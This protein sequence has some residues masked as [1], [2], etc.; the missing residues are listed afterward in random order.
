MEAEIRALLSG[1][2]LLQEHGPQD[3]E[4]IIEIDSKMLV[5]VVNQKIKASWKFWTILVQVFSLLRHFNFQIHH[6]YRE[7]NMVAD[8]LANT[9]L[10]KL[11]AQTPSSSNLGFI[12]CQLMSIAHPCP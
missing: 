2:L 5:D 10:P 1:L 9:G 4:L 12:L 3:Y 7:G 11:L 8:S 6:T